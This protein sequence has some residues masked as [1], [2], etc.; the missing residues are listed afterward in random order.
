MDFCFPWPKH[1]SLFYI[2]AAFTIGKIKK[3]ELSSHHFAHGIVQCVLWE[4]AA[5]TEKT[6]GEGARSCVDKRRSER[7]TEKKD[8]AATEKIPSSKMG[9]R[10]KR[11][12]GNYIQII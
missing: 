12:R 9:E 11:S 6:V 4:T 5:A 8:E 3:N 10:E 1:L 7:R 2:L